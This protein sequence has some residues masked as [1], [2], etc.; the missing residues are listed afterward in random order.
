LLLHQHKTHMLLIQWVSCRYLCTVVQ[1]A[2]LLLLFPTV[3]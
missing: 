1:I 3:A 2:H